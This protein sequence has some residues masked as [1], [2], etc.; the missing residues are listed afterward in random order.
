MRAFV[1]VLA[2]AGCAVEEPVEAEAPIEDG[3][4][5]E[6]SDVPVPEVCS[7]PTARAFFGD[8]AT[9][10]LSPGTELTLVQGPQAGYHIELGLT[11]ESPE[12]AIAWIIEAVD[13]ET[14]E[15]VGATNGGGLTFTALPSWNTETCTGYMSALEVRIGEGGGHPEIDACALD[16]RM[17]RVE[18]FTTLALGAAE[19]GEPQTSLEILVNV[20]C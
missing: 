12:Q 11:V 6:P 13:V 15:I 5:L 8:L 19:P 9:E 10:V 4:T 1:M 17:V 18:A 20:G 2:A 7:G 3:G 14:G 16:G